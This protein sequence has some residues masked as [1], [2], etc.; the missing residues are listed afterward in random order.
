MH[1]NF[2]NAL[3]YK[4]INKEKFNNFLLKRKKETKLLNNKEHMFIGKNI[5]KKKLKL[6]I[7]F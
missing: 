6:S 7:K 3:E 5:K 2:S 4:I 1:E